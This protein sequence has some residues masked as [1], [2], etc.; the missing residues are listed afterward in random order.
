MKKQVSAIYAR[1]LNLSSR[2]GILTCGGVSVPCVF[3]RSGRSHRKREGDGATPVGSWLLRKLYWRADRGFPP[4]TQLQ[5][6]V[7]RGDMGWCDAPE[8]GAYNRAVKLPY[9]ASHEEMWRTDGLY[10]VVVVLSHN[11]RPRIS[12]HGSAVFF[13][14]CGP[15][16]GPTAGCVA[17]SRGDM[18]KILERCGPATRL[19]VEPARPARARGSRK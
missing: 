5:R 6:R 12:G 9:A 17:V 18:A 10:D 4:E 19:V 15:D 8:D 2:K 1:A 13:H 3:G 16:R 11:E 7:L 14:L